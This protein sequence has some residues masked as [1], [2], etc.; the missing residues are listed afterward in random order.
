MGTLLMSVKAWDVVGYTYYA[1]IYCK[2]CGESLPE[3][4]PE[5][6]AKGAVFVSDDTSDHACDRCSDHLVW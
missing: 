6:N 4:D 2:A 1:S 5:G 3:I